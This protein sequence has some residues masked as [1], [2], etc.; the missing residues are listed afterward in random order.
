MAD[1]KPKDLAK[2]LKQENIR[3]AQILTKGVEKRE[4]EILKDL[5]L[6]HGDDAW[7]VVGAI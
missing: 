7:I 2:R 3:G 4:P 5:G 6:V 1:W